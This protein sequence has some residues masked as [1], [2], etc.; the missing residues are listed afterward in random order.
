VARAR[1]DALLA[2][3][4]ETSDAVRPIPANTSR[5][6]RLYLQD[7]SDGP[8]RE[9]APAFLRAEQHRLGLSVRYGIGVPPERFDRVVLRERGGGGVV[10]VP[11]A[12]VDGELYVG[13]I[14]QHRTLTGAGSFGLPM[15]GVDP[16]ED[17]IA[18]ARREFMEETGLERDVV[19]RLAAL[20][21]RPLNPSPGFFQADAR[22]GEGATFYALAFA[23]DELRLR[24]SSA[25]PHRVVYEVHSVASLCSRDDGEA[26]DSTGLRFF[27]ADLLVRCLSDAFSLV[28]IARL[29][30]DVRRARQQASGSR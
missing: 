9:I 13:V 2:L 22:Q 5:G 6:W 7:E 16:G 21:G 27:H 1:H 30:V 3:N 26:I 24:R 14:R 4:G 28:G 12:L 18:A 29:L 19:G 15:G 23:G 8:E 11:Y 25:N 10:I 20:P 17:R